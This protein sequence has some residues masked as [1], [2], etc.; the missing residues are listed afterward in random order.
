MYLGSVMLRVRNVTLLLNLH[1]RL[2]WK[3]GQQGFRVKVR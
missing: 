1:P 3:R 2:D